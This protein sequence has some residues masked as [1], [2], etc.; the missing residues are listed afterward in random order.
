MLISPKISSIA[1]ALP[2]VCPIADFM[3]DMVGQFPKSF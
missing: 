1:P 2:N 3:A